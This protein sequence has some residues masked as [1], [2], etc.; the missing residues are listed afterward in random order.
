MKKLL[1]SISALILLAFFNECIAQATPK[2]SMPYKATVSSS[3]TIGKA[4]YSKM[5]LDLWK[6]WDDNNFERHDY[7]ADSLVMMFPDGM[8]VK[9][10]QQNQE[11]AKKYRSKF[12]TVKSVVHAWVPLSSTDT[13][14]DAVCIW[15]TEEDTLPD[16]KVEKNDL[17]EVWWFNKDGKIIRMRQ[18]AAKFGSPDSK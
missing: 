4:A 2:E 10:K 16:G 9:G 18:W 5:I 13:K 12:T 11:A 17:H 8:V 7:I 6:D 1:I 15:G 14:E 3:F